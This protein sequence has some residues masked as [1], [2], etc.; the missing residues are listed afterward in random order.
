MNLNGKV[1]NPGE[2]RTP[3]TLE[4]PVLVENAGGAQRKSYVSQGT[5]WAKWVNAHGQ[6]SIQDG[7]L[8]ALRRA[9]VTIRYRSDVAAG[10][11]VTKGGE[12][13]EIIAPPDDIR[14]RHEYMELQVQQLKGTS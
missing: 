3:I 8:Q 12:R 9:T 7:A 6:E 5:A 4:S 10:W 13:Y 1:T 14:D 11:A 2:L